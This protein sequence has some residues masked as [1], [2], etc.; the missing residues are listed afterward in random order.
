MCICIV[1]KLDDDSLCAV[2]VTIRK[3]DS[4]RDKDNSISVACRDCWSDGD[5]VSWCITQHYGVG[6]VRGALKCSNDRLAQQ[7]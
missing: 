3:G 7:D 6:R 2:P 4:W 5:R 1:N